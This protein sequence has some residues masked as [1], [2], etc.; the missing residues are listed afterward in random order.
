LKGLEPG[1]LT[2]DSPA[3][4]VSRTSIARNLLVSRIGGPFDNA[5]RLVSWPKEPDGRGSNGEKVSKQTLPPVRIAYAGVSR[6]FC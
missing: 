3:G 5:F 4:K 2:S 1:C 6:L